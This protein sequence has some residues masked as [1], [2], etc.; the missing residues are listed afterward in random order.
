MTKSTTYYS[1]NAR[2]TLNAN[3]SAGDTTLVVASSIGFPSLSLPGDHFF[4]TIDDG[5]NLEIVKVTGIS[6]NSF[7]GCVRGQ[8][9][10]TARSFISTTPVENRLTSG[11]ITAFA[12]LQDRMAN[13][14]SLELLD[15]PGNSDCNS[16]LCASIDAIGAPIIAVANGSTWRLANYPDRVY[17]S[18]IGSGATTTSFT[19]TNIIN[20]LYDTTSHMYVMQVTSGQNIGL[21]RFVTTIATNSVSWTTALP[22][23]SLSTDTCEFYRCLS[24]WKM[25]TGGSADRIFFENDVQ[26]WTNYAIPAGKNAST[27]G[28]LTV[29]SGVTVTVPS[30]SAWSIL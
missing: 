18:Q 29:N 6:G 24:S 27:T 9:G 4:I 28:P 30:G 19:I 16:A 22:Y 7:V 12:R 17:S 8:E 11:N 21:C 26:L 10:T 1:N 15:S 3:I 23:V 5:T 2:T 20:Y 14:S 13:F 25:P